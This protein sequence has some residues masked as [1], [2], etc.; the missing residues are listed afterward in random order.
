[1]SRQ[2]RNDCVEKGVCDLSTEQALIQSLTGIRNSLKSG[3]KLEERYTMRTVDLD[4]EP[5]DYTPDEVKETRKLLGASQAVF[6]KLLGVKPRTIQSWEQG[7][8]PP[9]MACRLLDVINNDPEPWQE[10]LRKAAKEKVS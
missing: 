9:A 1:M 2:E 10:M 3:Q 5:R 8:V 4:L 6:A 7:L